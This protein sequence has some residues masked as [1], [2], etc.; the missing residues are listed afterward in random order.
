M[1][2]LVRR[3]TLNEITVLIPALNEIE[4]LGE[5]VPE[6][7]KVFERANE[8]YE[9]VTVLSSDA[10]PSEIKTIEKLG[11]IP[12]LRYPTNSFGD[13]IRCGIYTYRDFSKYLLIMDADGSHSAISITRMVQAA[14]DND[15]DVVIAS[16]YIRGGSTDNNFILRLMSR[17]LNILFR[18]V[19]GIPVMDISTNYKL[20]NS[21]VF[22]DMELTC[23]NFDII[24]EILVHIKKKIKKPIFI[25]I[26]DHFHRRKFGVSKRQL[27]PFIV[28]YLITLIRLRF[29]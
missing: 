28:S 14:R 17:S 24:E 12:L 8:K 29:R 27:G 26:P 16:R 25:E 10:A 7:H 23:R 22:K 4:N 2:D 18:F 19:I 6:I 9:I 21:R 1:R 13:A 11:A 15:A 5:L 20:Y 3:E